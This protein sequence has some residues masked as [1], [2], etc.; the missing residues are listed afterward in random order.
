[1]W[2]QIRQCGLKQIIWEWKSFVGPAHSEDI[3]STVSQNRVGLSEVELSS[4]EIGIN[5]ESVY[6]Q[7]QQ[8]YRN[9]M[10]YPN[11]V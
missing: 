10:A 8:K 1:M 4:V 11:S 3:D 7:S 2:Q 6:Y 5:R 9:K